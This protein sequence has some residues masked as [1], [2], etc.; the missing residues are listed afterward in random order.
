[1]RVLQ[2]EA[3][4]HRPY[5]EDR[6]CNVAVT[7]NIQCVG[8]FDGHGGSLIAEMCAFNFPLVIK[9]GILELGTPNMHHILK[10]SFHIMD[11]L[12]RGCHSPHVGSTAVVALIMDSSVWF[13]NAG[14]SMAMVVY[15]SGES[16]L[17]SY[18]HKVE[19][20]KERIQGEGGRIT[21]DDGCARVEQTLNVSRSIGDHHMKRHVISTPFIRSVSINF[22]QIKYV[23]MASDGV[24]DVYNKDHIAATF[25]NA[26]SV[27]DGLDTIL[28]ESITRGSDNVTMTYLDFA[29]G[30]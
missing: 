25:Q 5:M 4:G 20:E 12:A 30:Q 1:M 14:D 3:Q 24:W 17:V 7:K 10:Q 23:F 9:Q 8:I 6:W 19:N 18:E 11:E 2:R 15:L 27:D 16:E 22:K 29:C 13:A 26:P 28:R 21:Y